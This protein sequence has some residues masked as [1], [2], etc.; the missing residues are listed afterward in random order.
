MSRGILLVFAVVG[1]SIGAWAQEH[2]HMTPLKAS[3][4]FEQMKK[5]VG[6]WEGMAGKMP[7]KTEFRLTGDGSA[8]M[9]IMAEGTPY[10]MVTM[11]HMDGDRLMAT[12]YCAAHNQP[13]MVAESGGGNTI[14]FKYVDGTNIQPGYTHMENVRMTIADADHH[15]ELW[16]STEN[17]KSDAMEFDFHRVK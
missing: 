13:R 4:E 6:K 8:L 1:L 11:Y 3:P 17:G 15:K 10:E 12:H 9:E 7:S 5:L 2:E 14:E 16:T